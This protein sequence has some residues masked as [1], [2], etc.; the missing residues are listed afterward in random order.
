[1]EQHKFKF[2]VTEDS[3]ADVPLTWECG[4]TMRALETVEAGDTVTYDVGGPFFPI[5][6]PEHGA[7]FK[8]EVMNRMPKHLRY[9]ILTMYARGSK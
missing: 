5:H 1:M 7:K 2:D 6:C 4:C 9:T 8:L 3:D